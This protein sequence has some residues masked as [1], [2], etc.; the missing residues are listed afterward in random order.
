M[1]IE[2]LIPHRSPM[3]V[4]DSL[5][6]LS[7]GEAVSETVFSPDSIFLKADGRLEEAVLFEMMAQTFAAAMAV[8]RG[9]PS[10]S[11]G[12]LVGIKRLKI[13]GP[14][15]A[16]EPVRVAVKIINRVEDFSVIEGEVHQG[17]QP[18]AAGQITVFVPG[19]AAES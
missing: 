2:G 17:G 5:I 19:E 14:A 7:G 9:G 6:R 11:A 10:P 8:E 16:G 4:V 18:L 3:L 15:L 13:N 12:Y 1:K